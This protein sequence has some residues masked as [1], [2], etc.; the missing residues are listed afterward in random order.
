MTEEQVHLDGRQRL[1]LHVGLPKSGSTFL[2]SVLASNRLVLKQHGYVYPYVR[3][4]GMFYAAVEMAGRPQRW[5]LAPEDVAGTFAWLLRRGRRLGGT[6]V[7]SHEIFGGA[8]TGQIQTMGELLE[9][10]EVHLVVTARDLGRTMT[11]EWQERVKNEQ[12]H[13]FAEFADGVLEAIPSGPEDDQA[14]FWP[15]QNLGSLL[16]RWQAL[17]PPERIHVVVCPPRGADPGL[18]WTRFADALGLDPDAVDLSGVPVRN[19]SLGAAQ[20]SLLRQVLATLDG[21]LEQPWHSRV[22]KRW[23]AQTVLSGATS[24]KPVT[25]A[26]VVHRLAGV[27]EQWI[28]RIGSGGFAIHGDLA[29]LLPGVGDSQALHPDDADIAE[30]A[31]DLPRVIA[32]MLVRVKDLRVEIERLTAEKEQA[33][34]LNETLNTELSE[35][36]GEWDRRPRWWPF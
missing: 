14:A 11:A 31:D 16:D 34:A 2:Q 10:F 32:E 8:D 4:E 27:S 9:G 21:R 5:G 19:E 35:L 22:F 20:I 23:F 3:N 12:R 36:R 28:E 26:D 7:I 15:T 17:A 18:L 30:L 1:Y 24:A 29:D 25:P 33:E 13:S 6:V